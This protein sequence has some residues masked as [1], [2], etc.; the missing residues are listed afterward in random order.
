MPK[1]TFKTTALSILVIG[2][3]G[4][5]LYA[6]GLVP[7]L[8]GLAASTTACLL[9]HLLGRSTAEPA[10]IDRS[11][12]TV[13]RRMRMLEE[14]IAA[15]PMAIAVYGPDDVLVAHNS[16][17]EAVHS[18]AFRV[19]PK[20]IRYPDL[21]RLNIGEAS[22][23]GDMEAEVRKRVAQ[24]H[25]A[26]G[27]L[28]ERSY[29]DGSTR[30]VMKIRL[31]DGSIAGFAHDISEL[32]HRENDLT[33]SQAQLDGMARTTI[34]SAVKALVGAAFGLRS[35]SDRM[36]RIADES[37]ERARSTSV[38]AEEMS[39]AIAAVAGNTSDTARAATGARDEA[40]TTE[41]EIRKLS[42]ALAEIGT[43]ADV[44]RNIAQQTNLLALNAT[45]EAARAGDAGRGFAVV[46][47]E[48]KTLSGQTS[49][50]TIDIAKRLE[51]VQ[52][53]MN[54]ASEGVVRIGASIRQI[55]DMAIEIASAVEQQHLASADVARHMTVVVDRSRETGDAAGAVLD[56]VSEVEAT[57]TGL[58]SSV[59]SGLS[60][61]A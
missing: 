48:V 46:A 60:K 11:P 47:A 33:R 34:P 5:L 43:F 14:T 28:E 41:A 22:A 20:P 19:L 55:S 18:E 21:V 36:A 23:V 58:Q 35:S 30:R 39:A 61:A 29:A 9:G 24:Q 13:D 26:T 25:A 8:L 12:E 17:Y 31:S 49:E 1:P 38:A 44:I 42:A 59:E 7:A 45:I 53:L 4:V 10:P 52:S 3:A 56:L 32:R 37:A 54:N 16:A 40:S 6:H 2:C 57:A 51:L 50:A 15:A 27:V